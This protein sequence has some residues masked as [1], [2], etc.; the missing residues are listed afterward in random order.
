MVRVSGRCGA[1]RNGG[2]TFPGLVPAAS[3]CRHDWARSLQRVRQ[4]IASEEDYTSD[5]RSTQPSVVRWA[6]KPSSLLAKPGVKFAQAVPIILRCD[7]LMSRSP[8]GWREV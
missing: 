2:V 1:V 5:P 4:T 3:L 6:L 7:D 8:T